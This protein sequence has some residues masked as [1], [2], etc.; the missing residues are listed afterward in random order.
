[1]AV[2]LKRS[3]FIG[4]GGTGMKSILKTKQLYKDAFGEIPEIIGFLGID[5]STEEFAKDVK[6]FDDKLIKLEA[7]EQ[8]KM[9][10]NGPLDYYH[11]HKDRFYW[12][13][14]NN[15]QAL[16]GLSANG[17]GQIRTN[18]RFSFTINYSKVEAGVKN[19]INRVSSA[20]NDGKGK[21]DLVNDKIQIYL[22]FSLSGGTGCGIFLNMA[23]LIKDLYGDNCVL[24]AYAV[25]PNAFEG[26]GQFVGANAYGALLDTDYLMTYVDADTPFEYSLLQDDRK[27]F[28]KPFDL[29]YL[30]DNMNK[31]GDKYTDP[32]QLYTMIGQALLAIS[33][34]IGSASAADLDNF[35]QLMI[36]GS[37]DIEDKKSWASGMGLCEILVN[38]KK[39]SKKYR[40]KASQKL[41]DDM[42]G[43]SDSAT[44]DDI[45]M[46]WINVN[47]VREHE[48]DQVL[49]SL[50][51]LKKVPESVITAKKADRAETESDAYVS[52]AVNQA[53]KSIIAS[54][55]Q[56]LE[57]V[58]ISFHDKLI[59]ISQTG[60]LE[61]SAAFIFKITDAV[62]LYISEMRQEL[63]KIGKDLPQYK[64]EIKSIIEDWRN[65]RIF[66]RTDYASELSEAQFKYVSTEIDRIRHEKAVQFFLELKEYMNSFTASIKELSERLH[67]VLD[68]FRETLSA[69]E[70]TSND[71]NPFQIDL[72]ASFAVEGDSDVD[73]TVSR[74]CKLLPDNDIL[75]LKDLTSDEIVEKI[76]QFTDDLPG[77]D[78][79]DL[80]IENLILKLSDEKKTKLFEKALRKSEIILD[81]ENKG[82]TNEGALRNALYV[83][84][85]GG[86]D[87]AIAQDKIIS[88]LLEAETGP[89]KPTFAAA[90][91]NKSIMIFRQR[92]VYPIFQ[93][94]TITRQQR[95]YEKHSEKKSFSFDANLQRTLED[96]HYSFT[97]N[98]Q[99][100]DDVLEMWVK[101]LIHGLIKKDGQR[102][103][104]WSPALCNG[105]GSNDFMYKLRGA[106]EGQG[107]EA[108]WFAFEDFKSKKKQLKS[109][110]DLL[111]KI[112]EIED[113]MGKKSA[114]ELYSTVSKVSY[115]EY[116]EKYSKANITSQTINS[117]QSYANTKMVIKDED[118]YRRTKLVPSLDNRL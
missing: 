77:A 110:G 105:D 54:Y 104:V 101:G 107:T 5:T 2:K 81:I 83:S 87:G 69:I 86:K 4:L 19:V 27:T 32:N 63:D 111:S 30:I 20:T 102:Y 65:K 46:A 13:P 38:T 103:Y 24:Q 59:D 78:F 76:N 17:A 74:F 52:D 11:A 9:T 6:T 1:M 36:D 115:A 35:K 75:S 89:S 40:L 45:V 80:S 116:V 70:Y 68:L 58:K 97:P 91:T 60:G 94:A 98:Q 85:I 79:E 61:S 108:R 93:I 113:E 47:N 99:K 57:T 37:L 18:G 84:V 82:Y 109:R 53:M 50:Y 72:A 22:V 49:N 14:K 44:I 112:H 41:V 23:Y 25:L 33:G 15:V 100:D 29:I 10:M 56:K 95:D 26:C 88:Q 8:V 39:L 48:D 42:I 71:V 114:S 67:D 31:N 96:R 21:W 92:G 7:N 73:C 28:F 16:S 117:S 66:S 64:S 3:V 118:N 12:I 51:D 43:H 106:D 62:N 90:P 55:T 34:S